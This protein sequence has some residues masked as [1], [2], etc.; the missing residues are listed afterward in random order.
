MPEAI[1]GA[2]AKWFIF[3][4]SELNFAR[5]AKDI[6]AQKRKTLEEANL[7]KE[8]SSKAEAA[9]SSSTQANNLKKESQS[10]LL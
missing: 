8:C 1:A 2:G 3:F 6:M 4:F 7:A 9:L 5:K 10:C